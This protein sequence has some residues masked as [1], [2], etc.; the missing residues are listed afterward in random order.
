MSL[1]LIMIIR[2]SESPFLDF[3]S[4]INLTFGVRFN[5][6][7]SRYRSSTRRVLRRIGLKTY[8]FRYIGLISADT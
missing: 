3:D 7:K 1:V 4:Q 8:R 6:S 2:A 5:G